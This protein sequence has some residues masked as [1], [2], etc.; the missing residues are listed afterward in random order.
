MG[1][2]EPDTHSWAKLEQNLATGKQGL[3]IV[4][5]PGMEG[6]AE[7][8]I[9]ASQFTLADLGHTS[10]SIEKLQA[11]CKGKR[12]GSDALR[13]STRCL[14]TGDEIYWNMYARG[15]CEAGINCLQQNCCDTCSNPAVLRQGR[16]SLPSLSP[17]LSEGLPSQGR[18]F[19]G[20][21][22]QTTSG[23]LP[24]VLLY[25]MM[26]VQ[27]SQ[28]RERYHRELASTIVEASMAR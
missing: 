10:K 22:L 8:N 28:A 24:C 21:S 17:F 23:A 16:V 19:Y 15:K 9:W 13:L 2:I 11:F 4:N 3:L 7:Q 1:R 20:F 26:R 14:Q 12:T 5:N 27:R 6:D 25:C 18:P